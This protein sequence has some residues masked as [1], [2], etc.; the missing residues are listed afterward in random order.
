[1]AANTT[2]SNHMPGLR[3]RYGHGA[4][5]DRISTGYSGYHPK[6]DGHRM[7]PVSPRGPPRLAMWRF[8]CPMIRSDAGGTAGA[9]SAAARARTECCPRK[10]PRTGF[11]SIGRLLT[12]EVLGSNLPNRSEMMSLRAQQA[13]IFR[14]A[15]SLWRCAPALART[16]G[17]GTTSAGRCRRA[18]ADRVRCAP[19]SPRRRSPTA[20]P[21]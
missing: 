12:T 15:T 13:K 18:R 5:R 20:A 17:G 2:L 14:C 16:Y 6:A 10:S 4:G 8:G 19:S 11:F 7:R 21:A 1:M 9:Q 3:L